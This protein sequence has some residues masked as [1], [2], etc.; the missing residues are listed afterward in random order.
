MFEHLNEI[1][2]A[3]KWVLW[4]IPAVVVLAVLWWVFRS[5]RQH[6]AVRVS[7]IGAFKGFENPFLSKLKLLIPLFR[8]AAICMLLV[9]LA[10]PQIMYDEEKVTNEGIDIVL[11][12]DVSMSMLAQDF[13]PNRLDAAK[14]EATVFMDEREHDRIGLVV[15]A[16]ESHSRCPITVDHKIVK[17]KMASIK[18]GEMEDGTAIGMGLATAV[19]R[20]KDAEAKSKVVILMTDGVNNKGFIDPLTACDLAVRENVRVY[21]IGIGTNGMAYSPIGMYPNGKIVY[22]YTEVVIDEPLLKK[23]ASRTGGKY[24]RATGNT[25]LKEIYEQIDMLE[26]TKIEVSAFEKTT[27]KF[28][29]FALLAGI[30]VLLEMLFRYLLIRGLP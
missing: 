24:F 16:G 5:R 9:A 1:Q 10:R 15:F 17:Q 4:L 29:A 12:M 3:N 7:S 14:K 6:A 11:A 27:E 21:T 19:Q 13:K 25:R 8:L 28:H 26:K 2:F 30:M 22:D 23:I 20:L 18:N